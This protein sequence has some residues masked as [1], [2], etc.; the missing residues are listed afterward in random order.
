MRL[1]FSAVLT[2]AL[3]S[4]TALA[5]SPQKGRVVQGSYVDSGNIQLPS[6]TVRYLKSTVFVNSRGRVSG[7]MERVVQTKK[8]AV[9]QRIRVIVRGTVRNLHEK[10]GAFTARALL[11]I[12]D[13]SKIN[14]SFRG[15]T[16]SGGRLSRFFRGKFSG[17]ADSSF[18]LRSR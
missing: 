6:L 1:A 18:I 13:G 5:L 14:G 10:N 11:R 7:S 3:F 2:A 17:I 12:N 4:S 16:G 15:L 8:G 9:L